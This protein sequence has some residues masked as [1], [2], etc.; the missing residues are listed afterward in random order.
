MVRE[1][2][3]EGSGSFLVAPM[4]PDALRAMR[5]VKWWE[6]STVKMWVLQTR[7]ESKGDLKPEEVR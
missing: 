3:S 2:D 6:G 4:Y 7:V 1:L 5:D